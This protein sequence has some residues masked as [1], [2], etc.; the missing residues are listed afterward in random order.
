MINASP[1]G[2]ATLSSVP[3]P[4]IPIA[5]SAWYTPQTVPKRPTNGAVAPTVASTVRPFSSRLI[6]SSS[7]FLS[8][9]VT[10]SLPLPASCSREAP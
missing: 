2:P 5:T 7:T 6:S 10:N 4:L 1:T 9:R 3:E 8:V